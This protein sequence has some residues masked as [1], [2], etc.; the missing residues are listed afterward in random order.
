MKPSTLANLITFG[1]LRLRDGLKPKTAPATL[2]ALSVSLFFATEIPDRPVL[3]VPRLLGPNTN[4]P[5]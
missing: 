4:Q 1:S 3:S 5:A 2:I